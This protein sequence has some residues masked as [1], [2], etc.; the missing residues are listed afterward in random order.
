[1]RVNDIYM[2]PDG[3]FIRLATYG[4][5]IWQLAQLELQGSVI[6]DGVLSCDNDGVLDNSE[7]GT[8]TITLRNQGP[9]NVNQGTLTFTSDNPHVTFPNGNRIPVPP[10]SKGAA[11]SASIA[12]ALAGAVG[13]ENVTFTIA[14][15]APELALSTPITVTASN[16]STTTSR[17]TP[18]RPRASRKRARR[19]PSSAARLDTPNIFNWQRR[20]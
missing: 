10:V 2:P 18:P 5:G 16:A 17:R 14:I 12:V 7:T 15:N 13:I 6:S 19:G 9:N 8:L 3:S 1:V 11:A 4:R 20:H